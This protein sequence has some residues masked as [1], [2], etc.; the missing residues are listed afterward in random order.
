MSELRSRGSAQITIVDL[1]DGRRIITLINPNKQTQVVYDPDSNKYIPN[2]SSDP[3][4][5]TPQLIVEGSSD[6]LISQAD[7]IKW[8]YQMN[9]IGNKI[10]I[11][12][13]DG[14]F[15]LGM[16]PVKTLT[17]K[18]N[19]FALNQSIRI[20]CTV[21]YTDKATDKQYMSLATIEINKINNGSSGKNAIIGLLS[22][23]AQYISVNDLSEEDFTNLN[24]GT[25]FSIFDGSVDVTANWNIEFSP[26]ENVTGILEGNNFKLKT[27]KDQEG[28]VT[29]TAKRTGFSDV[30]KEFKLVKITNGKDGSSINIETNTPVIKKSDQGIY[31]PRILVISSK[32]RI[33]NNPPSLSNCSFKISESLSDGGKYSQIYV[34]SELEN[35]INYTPSENISSIKIELFNDV[36]QSIKIDEEIIPIVLD[37]KDSVFATIMTP[38]GITS[39]N[40]D[41]NLIGQLVLYKG[42]NIVNGSSYQWYRLKPSAIGDADSGEGWEKLVDTED[43]SIVGSKTATISIS[44]KEIEGTDTFMAITRFNGS[45]IKQTIDFSDLN[46]PYIVSIIGNQIFKNSEGTNTYIAKIYLNGDEV[47][48][49]AANYEN[50]YNWSLYNTSGGIIDG[51][52]KNGKK[53]TIDSS[54]LPGT[55]SLVLEV[56][57]Q[58]NNTLGIDR[59]DLTDLSDAI[60]SGTQPSSTKEGQLWIDTSNGGNILKVYH[61]GQWIIQELDV[62]KL[63]SG[64]AKVIEEINDTLGSITDDNKLTGQDRVV[65]AKDIARMIGKYPSTNDTLVLQTLP[66]G[67]ELDTLGMGEYASSRKSAITVG[68]PSNDKTLIDVG[69]AYNALAGY[70]N[71]AGTEKVPVWDIRD[72]NQEIVLDIDGDLF[73][74]KWLDY[75]NAMLALQTKILSIPGPAGESSITAMLDNDSATIST[76]WEGNNGIYD[77]ATTNM[78]VYIGL[79]ETSAKWTFTEEHSDGITLVLKDNN[80]KIT[81]ITKDS[82]YV[83]ITANREG[84]QSIT[85]RFSVTRLKAAKEG[86]S[87]QQ[88]WLS[89]SSTVINKDSEGNYL[90]SSITLK[91]N[92]KYGSGVATPYPAI[93]KID[94]SSNGTDYVNVYHTTGNP[95]DNYVYR[96]SK[97]LKSILVTLLENDD[98][99]IIDSQIISIVSD[100]KNGENGYTPVKGVDYFDGVSSYLHM[101]YSDDG[102]KTF[103]A[104]NG[105]TPGLYVGSYV[106]INKEDSEDVTKYKWVKFVGESAKYFQLSLSSYVFKFNSLG[107]PVPADQSINITTSYGGLNSVNPVIKLYGMKGSV[108]EEITA[109]EGNN[110]SISLMN[111]YDSLLVE[112]IYGKYSDS[113][114]ISKISDGKIGK[115]SVSSFLSSDSITIVTNSEGNNGNY[116]NAMTSLTIMVGSLNETESWRISVDFNTNEIEGTLTKNTFK[117]DN[118]MVDSSV[119]TFNASKEGNPNISKKFNITKVKNGKDTFI[120]NITSSNG[121]SFKGTVNTTLSCK[122]FKGNKDI[123]DSISASSFLWKR[124]SN[125]NSSDTTWNSNDK[126]K[127]KKSIVI[128]NADMNGDIN[129]FYCIVTFDSENV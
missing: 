21:E 111:G 92:I 62:T 108:K 36:E 95:I 82:G 39:R 100:G 16:G 38:N 125:N 18:E 73:R 69:T 13:S 98:T 104:N 72:I 97:N 75:Y 118:L 109:F 3:M 102:G 128:G 86:E 88:K 123:T 14:P 35:T 120:T 29:F 7:S 51:F 79:S 68:I 10:E 1:T 65:I 30:N 90:P 117:V 81:G 58:S 116:D 26:S 11:T 4:T 59:I 27:F 112:G 12:E 63:D 85:K 49:D 43:R 122:V 55:S 8:E 91:S 34:S 57:D 44:P 87:A 37:G 71:T 115:D 64:L 40:S 99:T 22:N 77:T 67:E 119:V 31:N 48:K 83:D 106:D 78:L 110:I 5:L 15:E 84:Y 107:T 74:Q 52:K 45:V 9:S 20:Y 105:S 6:D 33:G 89:L 28:K 32:E 129:T 93:F 113:A 19:I 124:K 94:E 53:I 127:G 80:V 23:D 114:L 56:L 70:L 103:T 24:I 96:P 17:I 61:N 101:R 46:D 121:N 41:K 76:D 25:T 60:I 126:T 2:Y 66:T 42:T 47:D 54:E 50:K